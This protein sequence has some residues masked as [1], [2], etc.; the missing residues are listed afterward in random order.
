MSISP[1]YGPCPVQINSL[2]AHPESR[3]AIATES[4]SESGGSIQHVYKASAGARE[5]RVKRRTTSSVSNYTEASLTTGRASN[6]ASF[7]TSQA[8]QQQR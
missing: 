1:S 8:K 2:A 3:R 4:S 6:G 5:Q 7:I